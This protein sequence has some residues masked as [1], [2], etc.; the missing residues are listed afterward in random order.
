MT[1]LLLLNGDRVGFL[2]AENDAYVYSLDNAHHNIGSAF[3]MLMKI[4]VNLGL[5]SAS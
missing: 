3:S 4:G 1:K 5:C 2:F